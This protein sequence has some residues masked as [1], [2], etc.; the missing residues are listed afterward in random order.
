MSTPFS[1]KFGDIK[2]IVHRYLPI[3]FEDQTCA[4]L[5]K[6]GI[7]IFSRR[8]PTLGN[9]LSLTYLHFR[10]NYCCGGTGCC[11]HV[12]KVNAVCSYS[13]KR[14]HKIQSFFNCNTN[15][16]IYII[17]CKICYVQ[18]IGRTT[19]R[20]RDRFYEHLYSIEKNKIH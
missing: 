19:R 1:L 10:G 16:V 9:S 5:L 8:A 13:A 6:D 2:N 12:N 17:T 11:R 4:D 20:L 7:N 18:Y 15:Y 14:E 3:V